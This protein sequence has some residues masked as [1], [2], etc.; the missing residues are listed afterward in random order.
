MTSAMAVALVVPAA[1]AWAM[2]GILRRSPLARYLVDR[3][4]ERSLHVHP[5]PRV[6]GVAL[7]LAALPVALWHADRHLMLVLSCAAVLAIVSVADDL[8]SL[9]IGVR[10]AAHLAAAA[11]AVSE[12]GAV[13]GVS[14]VLVL[15]IAWM[16]NLYN[17]MDGADG[18]AGGMAAIGFAAY[19]FAAHVGGQPSLAIACL[20]FASAAVG[21][22]AWNFPPARVFLGDCG[23]I[24][25]G[26]LAGTLGLAGYLRGAWPLWFPA[27]VFSPFIVDASVTLARRTLAGERPWRA[28]RGHYYQRLVL[29]GWSPRRLAIA[30]YV[31]MLASAFGAVA[32]RTTGL[33]LQ[34][35][36]IAAAAAL[37]ALLLYKIEARLPPA[38]DAPPS[39]PH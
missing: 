9:A 4:N 15:A 22:L 36:I 24:P 26:F 7:M 33:M 38:G 23:S 10:L 5:T 35:G 29:S 14:V 18:L 32:G 39:R 21:F 30:A 3:P 8:R 13:G 37:Y 17:F 11:L 12:L 28:H 27:L 19:A 2:I 16:T 20:A 34:C 6:G 1:I 25:L 31:L